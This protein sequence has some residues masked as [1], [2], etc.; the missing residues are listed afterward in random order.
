MLNGTASSDADGDPLTYA[1]TLTTR[2]TGSAATLAGATTATPSFTPD[3]AGSYI[4]R[5]IVN[6]GKTDSAPS[7][8]TITATQVATTFHYYLFGGT[9]YAT[10]LGC[11][12]CN[13]F[14]PESVC[15]AFGTYGNQFSASSIWNE[16]GTYGNPF[17]SSSPWNQ[18]STS[19]PAIIGSDDLFYGYFTT[20]TFQ[21]NR[22]T[23]SGFVYVLDYYSSTGN[24]AATRTVACGN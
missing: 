10:Y 12:T 6:D 16:F 19:G 14:E 21:A 7:T 9:G 13:E 20:N 5:L 15:N 11:L 3:L 24:L 23:I 17:S 2:P 8:V 1:W 18:Y 22:T 4:A